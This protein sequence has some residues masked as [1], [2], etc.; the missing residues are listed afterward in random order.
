MCRRHAPPSARRPRGFTL[1]EL[2]ITIAVLTVLAG[3]A[4]PAMREFT[5]RATVSAT[6]NDLVLALNLARSEAVKRGRDVSL[7]AVGADWSAGWTIEPVGLAE[8]LVSH[9][10]VAS[11]YSVL[12]AA[13]GGAPGDRVTFGATGA[14]RVATAYD[15]SVCRP[16]FSPGNAQSRRILVAATGT[17]RSR[18]DTTGSPA[19]AC[20]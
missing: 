16:T 9:E 19:G 3:L 12:G 18:R 8:V 1:L 13:A 15:F 2:L 14:L 7:I 4:V 17:V 10:A 11:E 5:V 6:T 20:P